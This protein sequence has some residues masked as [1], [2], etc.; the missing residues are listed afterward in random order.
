MASSKNGTLYIHIY[1]YIYIYKYK[2]KPPPIVHT[3][4]A[5]TVTIITPLDRYLCVWKRPFMGTIL[6]I[7][8]LKSC[9]SDVMKYGVLE[10]F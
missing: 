6:S 8:Y 1:I 2:V 5:R 10:L 4:F 9:M 7:V 3:R